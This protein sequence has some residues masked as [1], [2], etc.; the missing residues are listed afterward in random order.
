MK[1]YTKHIQP[2]LKPIETSIFAI[3]S[4]MANDYQA[5]NLSQGFPDF[6][7]DQSLIDRV[8]HFMQ[9]GY[10]QYAPM[11]GVQALREEIVKLYQKNHQKTYCSETEVTIT[12]G[13]TQ[14]LFTAISAIIRKGDEAI[15]FQPAYDSY[16]PAIEMSGG[17]VKLSTLHAPDFS[18]NW[19]EVEQLISD[20]TRLIVLNTPHNPTGSVLKHEDMLTLNK[21][22]KDKDI[23]LISDEVYEYLIFEGATHYSMARYPDLAARAFIIGSFGKSLHATGWKMGYAVA[24]QF[25]MKEFRKVHQFNVFAVNTPIQMAI[26]DYLSSGVNL[27]D[28]GDFYQKKRD[29][30][31][32]RL[33]DSRFTFIPAMGTYFQTLDYSKISDKKDT[34]FAEELIKEHGIASVPLSPFYYTDVN[35]RQLRFC[36][37][38]KEETLNKALDILC[39]I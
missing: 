25:L 6:E 28:L 31:L 29:L 19:E 9:T 12:A 17:I 4:K 2:K 23:I 33:K 27:F 7:I 39:K 24:P 35:L 14:A 26:A 1:D 5:V 13:A 36:F 30:F 38:K 32:N 15:V 11:P 21:L 16:V 8:K 22:V 10:N 37:A 18:V 3:M 20:K 34:D